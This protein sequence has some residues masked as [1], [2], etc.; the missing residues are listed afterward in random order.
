MYAEKA[1]GYISCPEQNPSEEEAKENE[2]ENEREQC[3]PAKAHDD[4]NKSPD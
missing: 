3:K 1:S 2:N 4:I